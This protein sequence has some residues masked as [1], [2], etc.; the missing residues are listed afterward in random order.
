[1]EIKEEYRSIFA[2]EAAENIQEWEGALLTL[3][4]DPQNRELVHTMFRSIHTLKGSAGFIGFDQLQR[5]TH[6]LESALQTVREGTLELASDSVDLLFRGLDLARDMVDSFTQGKEF[7]DDIEGFLAELKAWETQ[8]GESGGGQGR[9]EELQAAD[10][11]DAL[12]SPVEP[13]A[14]VENTENRHNF[15]LELSIE[16]S[17]REG[18]LR[19]FLVRNRLAGLATILSEDPA[20]EILRDSQQPFEYR[21]TV[22][23]CGGEQEL[24]EA[25][26]IDLLKITSIKQL[27]ATGGSDQDGQSAGMESASTSSAV[28]SPG[29]K[30]ESFKSDEVVRVSVD[31]LDTLLNLVGELVIQNSSFISISGELKGH[32]GKSQLIGELEAKTEGLSKIIRDLQDGIMKVRMLPVNNVFSRFYRVVRDLAKVRGKEITLDVFGQDTEIDKKVMDR[33]ADPL[34]HL[35]RNAIDHGIESREQRSA[36]G[37]ASKGVVRLG[38]YQDGDHICIEVSDD[39]RGLDR[40]KI[41]KKAIER[42]LVRA[43]EAD[44]LGDESV[45]GLIFLPGFTTADAVSEV[46]GRGVGMDAVRKAIEGMGGSI[47]IRSQVGRGTTITIS[48]PLTMAIIPALLVEVKGATLAVPLSSVT[49]VL[50]VE[51]AELDS[52]GLR[53]IVR[54]RE[55]VLS[56]VTLQ[57]ALQLHGNGS[58]GGGAENRTPVVVVEYESRRIGLGVQRVLGTGEIVIKSLSRHYRE[59]EGLIGASILGNGRIALIVDVE[60]LVRRYYHTDGEQHARSGQAIFS[61]QDAT[62]GEARASSAGQPI[63]AP[64]QDGQEGYLQ[65]A[66]AAVTDDGIGQSP[67]GESLKAAVDNGFAEDASTPTAATAAEQI[68]PVP[69]S[70]ASL[71]A[72]LEAR[73]GPLLEQVHNTGAIQASIS[74]SQMTGQEIRVS[75]PESKLVTIGEVAELLG[76][77]E[78]A[79]GG[80]YV[81]LEG[82]L[83][84]GILMVLPAENLQRFHDFLYRR[85]SGSCTALEEVDLS[86]I[87]ELGNVLSAS[88]INAMCDQTG[89]DTKASAPEIS[90]DMCL[91]VI[92][93][94]LSRFNQPGEQLLLTKTI[95]FSGDSEEVGCHLLMFLE[96]ESLTRLLDVLTAES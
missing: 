27:D 89:L 16:S 69:V 29:G 24:L 26:N 49:E 5:L 48:L 70:A 17:G 95:V 51:K 11:I 1:M 67:G 94:V 18:F 38:A 54:L 30:V 91:S 55:E 87:S 20:P 80:I 81:G 72:D 36:A 33:I 23:T 93:A 47:R 58:G 22:E 74:L 12:Q 46:S 4:H 88:F 75:F 66:A 92:D 85:P 77:E 84:G 13:T 31:R 34:V 96:P 63:S 45:L 86:G 61:Y 44:K 25:L 57:D 40:E 19:A 35:V 9:Q 68:P 3:E 42:Q 21:I 73:G 62:A 28:S 39:G 56:L 59:I 83:A 78:K 41:L 64:M 10:R 79:T 52:I 60:A 15:V 82:K 37:K 53:P 6:E 2:E 76:G 71:A 43:E 8:S 50:K 14:A 90:V 65:E 32:Y 7:Q